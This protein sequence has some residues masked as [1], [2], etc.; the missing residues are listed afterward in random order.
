MEFGSWDPQLSA[1]VNI[2]YVGTHL[3]NGQPANSTACTTFFD[4]SGFIMGT[5]ASFFNVSVFI[6]GHPSPRNLMIRHQQIFDPIH[7]IILGFDN[8][9][10]SA[11]LFMLSQ[12]GNQFPSRAEGVADWPNV[13][14]FSH[15]WLKGVTDRDPLPIALF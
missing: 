9:S 15:P 10:S 11:V 2:S 13:R 14:S 3:S 4:Q 12:L 5:S 8:S 7:N 1:M 6:P